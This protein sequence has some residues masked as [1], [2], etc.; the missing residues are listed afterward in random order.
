[1]QHTLRLLSHAS[2]QALLFVGSH[3]V[4]GASHVLLALPLPPLLL[5][6]AAPYL[7]PVPPLPGELPPLPDELPPLPGVESLGAHAMHELALH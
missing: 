2:Q 1:M 3:C 4:P 6:P 5:A 7:P